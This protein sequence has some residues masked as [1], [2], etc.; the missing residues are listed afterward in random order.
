MNLDQRIANV[1]EGVK[2][3]LTKIKQVIRLLDT[4][5]THE[6]DRDNTDL[7]AMHA[8][9]LRD[10]ADTLVAAAMALAL[11]ADLREQDEPDRDD[12]F[13]DQYTMLARRPD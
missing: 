12:H 8:D 1:S 5:L 2:E 3:Q 7:I 4:C 9:D 10:Y 11:F 13:S 6:I